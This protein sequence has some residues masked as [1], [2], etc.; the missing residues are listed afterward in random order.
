[1]SVDGALAAAP[2]PAE[3]AFKVLGGHSG[4]AL[5]L[6]EGAG[7]SVVRKT[8]AAPAANL[9]LRQQAIKQ[10]LL[11]AQGFA[12]PA[13]H[14]I[15]ADDTGRAFFEM[16]YV[17]ARTLAEI[18][19]GAVP[20]GRDAILGAVA[21]FVRACSALSAST[22]P[23]AAFRAKIESIAATVPGDAAVAGVA[24]ELL[25]RGWSDI[26]HSPDHGDLTLENILLAPDQSVVFIDCDVAW[27]S[28]WWLDLAKLFQDLEGHWCLRAVPSPSIDALERLRLFAADFRRLA[29]ALDPALPRRLAQLAALHLLRTLPYARDRA[30]AAFAAAAASRLLKDG[31]S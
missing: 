21:H 8:A 15:G 30:T 7:R 28:S 4:A 11:A 12:F 26:P 24:R 25:A 23:A 1:M 22:I 31:A 29:Q 5:V 3:R 10:R 14:R 2:V 19:A 17:P 16:D 6:C 27:V 18:V 9:R 20:C 13:V